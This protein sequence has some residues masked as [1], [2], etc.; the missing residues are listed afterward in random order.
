MK[1]FE[2][3]VDDGQDV[4]KTFVAAQSKK[5]LLSVY[6]GNGSF[7][8]I[9]DVTKDYFTN[10]SVDFLRESLIKTGWGKGE[11][12]LITAL[13]DEHIKKQNK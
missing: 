12:E 1:L 11:I 5:E 4:F 2:C 8:K 9:K 6:G 10:T 7:E 3:I 13:L